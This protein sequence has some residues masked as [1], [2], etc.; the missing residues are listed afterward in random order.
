MS[1]ELNRNPEQKAR[2]QIDAMLRL[3]GWHVQSRNDIDFS[4]GIGVAIREY[5]TSVGPADYILFVNQKPL[6][7]IEAKREDEGH[8][9]TVVEGQSKEYAVAKLNALVNAEPLKYVYESTG[10]VTRYTDHKPRGKNVFSFHKPET[11]LG[12]WR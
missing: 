8:R 7:I 2:D 11:F 1:N 10:V 12:R 4:V 5:Q 3:A 9:L 6:G